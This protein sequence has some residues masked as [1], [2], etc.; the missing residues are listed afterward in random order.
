MFLSL[1]LV[2]LEVA[3]ELGKLSSDP[4]PAHDPDA[5]PID[6]IKDGAAVLVQVAPKQ[7]APLAQDRVRRVAVARAQEA[8]ADTVA[9]SL[10]EHADLAKDG[11]RQHPY[12]LCQL[13]L[14][15]RSQPLRY[16]LGDKKQ[17]TGTRNPRPR[18][19]ST[20]LSASERGRHSLAQLRAM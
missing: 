18:P 14:V 6:V 19:S 16:D 4:A 2:L 10:A 12:L 17:Y 3:A 9:V 5:V 11:R 13:I 7:D 15:H 8:I 1:L 20:K